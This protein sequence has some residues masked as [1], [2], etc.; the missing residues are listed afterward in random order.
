MQLEL[1]ELRAW[2]DEFAPVGLLQ[3]TWVQKLFDRCADAEHRAGKLQGIVEGL[4]E[5]IAQQS[6]LLS[7]K[8]EVKNQTNGR[9]APELTEGRAA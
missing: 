3:A 9:L 1:T 2:A 4:C 5:R 7:R 6:E 8:A